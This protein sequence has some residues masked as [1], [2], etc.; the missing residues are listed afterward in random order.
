MEKKSEFIKKLEES[1]DPED[2]ADAMALSTISRAGRE[3]LK[4]QKKKKQ[5][6]QKKS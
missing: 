5:M 1:D 3:L 2:R 4:Q 6:R